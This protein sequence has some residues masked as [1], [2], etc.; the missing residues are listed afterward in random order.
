MTS[1]V[2]VEFGI[3]SLFGEW[4]P[5]YEAAIATGIISIAFTILV[6]VSKE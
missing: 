6:N 2:M 4:T 3:S 5:S 1:L